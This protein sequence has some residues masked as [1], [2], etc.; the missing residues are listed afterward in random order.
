MLGRSINKKIQKELEDRKNAL[1]RNKVDATSG[2]KSVYSFDDLAVRTTYVRL[3]S[4]VYGT[5]IKGRLL[6]QEEFSYSEGS[7][8][9]SPT[10]EK[11]NT[12]NNFDREYWRSKNRGATPPPGI[13][14]VTTGFMGEGATLNTTKEATIELSCF[15]LLQYEQLVEEFIMIGRILYLEFGWSNPKLDS[16]RITADTRNFLTTKL[17]GEEGN[18]KPQVVL[19]LNEVQKYPQELA[20]NTSGNTDVFVGVVKNYEA[21]ANENGGFDFTI[22]MATTGVAMYDS[23]FGEDN[24]EMVTLSTANTPS[25][26]DSVSSESKRIFAEAFEKPSADVRDEMVLMAK[27]RAIIQEDFNIKDLLSFSYEYTFNASTDRNNSSGTAQTETFRGTQY[28]VYNTSTEP[29]K[30]LESLKNGFIEQNFEAEVGGKLAKKD[31]NG[32]IIEEAQHKYLIAKHKSNDLIISLVCVEA[33]QQQG[34]RI[35]SK[36]KVT[37]SKSGRRATTDLDAG[38]GYAFYINYYISMRYLEDNVFNRIFGVVDDK[39]VVRGGIRSCYF[40]ETEET[41]ESPVDANGDPYDTKLGNWDGTKYKKHTITKTGVKLVNNKMMMHDVL[42]PKNLNEVLI[43]TDATQ[44]VL[45]RNGAG[46]YP[47]KF[48]KVAISGDGSVFDKEKFNFTNTD[49]KSYTATLANVLSSALPFFNNDEDS[50]RD[51]E[52]P[53]TSIPNTKPADYRHMYVNVDIVQR[54]FLGKQNESFYERNQFLSNKQEKQNK[55]IVVNDKEIQIQFSLDPLEPKFQRQACVSTFKE[56]MNNLLNTI[57]NNLHKLPMFELGGNVTL[58][59]YLS[60]LDMRYTKEDVA[61]TFD[62]F[63]R[64]SIVKSVDLASHV[65]NL[66]QLAAYFGTTQARM[67]RVLG[68]QST[69]VP[70]DL[71]Q[72]INERYGKLKQKELSQA[73]YRGLNFGKSEYI[74]IADR[75]GDGEK[76]GNYETFGSGKEII[77]NLKLL[78]DKTSVFSE[79]ISTTLIHTPST[80]KGKSTS[81]NTDETPEDLTI[82]SNIPGL[83][84]QIVDNATKINKV[85]TSLSGKQEPEFSQLTKNGTIL[86]PTDKIIDNK[87]VLQEFKFRLTEGDIS[88]DYREPTLEIKTHPDFQHYIDTILYNSDKQSFNKLQGKISFFTL[89]IVIDGIAGIQPGDAFLISHFPTYLKSKYYFIVTNLEQNLSSEGWSTTITAMQKP[90][91][92]TIA[93]ALPIEEDLAIAYTPVPGNTPIDYDASDEYDPSLIPGRRGGN[94]DPL[95][96][97]LPAEMNSTNQRLLRGTDEDQDPADAQAELD[98]AQRASLPEPE[99]NPMPPREADPPGPPAPPDAD[100]DA[101]EEAENRSREQGIINEEGFA[102]NP[103]LKL[104]TTFPP[105]TYTKWTPKVLPDV[106]PFVPYEISQNGTADIII[107]QTAD[108]QAQIQLPPDGPQAEIKVYPG[109]DASDPAEALT[110]S[111]GVSDILSVDEYNDIVDTYTDMGGTSSAIEATL[112]TIY[113]KYTI[114]DE[115]E[116]TN[117]EEAGRKFGDWDTKRGGTSKEAE[118]VVYVKNDKVDVINKLANQVSANPDLK[119]PDNNTASGNTYFDDILHAIITQPERTNAIGTEI[120]LPGETNEVEI[121]EVKQEEPLIEEGEEDTENQE[122]DTEEQSSEDQQKEEVVVEPIPEQTKEPEPPIVAST[123]IV[124]PGIVQPVRGDKQ[125]A[126]L[127]LADNIGVMRYATQQGGGRGSQ[128]LLG[129]AEAVLNRP[130]G[131]SG[132][133][134]EVIGGKS[135]EIKVYGY[136]S[137]DQFNDM[138]SQI[139]PNEKLLDSSR[140]YKKMFVGVFEFYLQPFSSFEDIIPGGSSINVL[141]LGTGQAATD[142]DAMSTRDKNREFRLAARTASR[143]A[144]RYFNRVFGVETTYDANGNVIDG[145]KEN[146]I[147]TRG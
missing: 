143:I 93:N 58:P 145:V 28:S 56:G 6:Q 41:I 147:I 2:E 75:M 123:R 49:Y 82:R 105:L 80:S 126:S 47:D 57:S 31:K 24:S 108:G 109:G 54:A 73:K 139:Y 46:M 3:V 111:L 118:L 29:T 117:S 110:F 71:L 26:K 85:I 116:V 45:Q 70:I 132:I 100:Y 97:P 27:L 129:T 39:G 1:G 114:I 7:E 59:D 134:P 11:A 35:Q 125:M 102:N 23:T 124:T 25:D 106:K 95:T 136:V 86:L 138:F 53:A 91:R 66:V 16:K 10:A 69:H 48:E 50:L 135:G 37:N 51:S 32:K 20:L 74:D 52:E 103:N 101:E 76:D 13:T 17:E 14:S 65:P 18:K 96:G 128:L 112:N 119:D 15:S 84:G 68:N 87:P 64:N 137:K 61:Y 107:S 120:V 19:D 38:V 144:G 77:S 83:E 90:R 122:K 104:G 88:E 121:E 89:T 21:K 22:S 34:F 62:S 5:E 113:T 92:K 12:M 141:G 55:T 67:D 140:K 133:T 130:I 94:P 142:I 33:K 146:T 63:S 30:E 44:N 72:N 127:R 131:I 60:V 78:A 81:G 115:D 99:G 8:G 40:R 36:E 9:Q 42:V 79:G 4:P 43:N 98:S